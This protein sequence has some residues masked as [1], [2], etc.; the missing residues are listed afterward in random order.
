MSIVRRLMPSDFLHLTK[1][2]CAIHTKQN[3]FL[4]Q[5]AGMQSAY[6]IR[7]HKET[8]VYQWVLLTYTL[9]L[10]HRKNTQCDIF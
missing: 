9:T 7:R 1:V 4:S 2:E 5:Q 10:P 8:E 3:N 6:V